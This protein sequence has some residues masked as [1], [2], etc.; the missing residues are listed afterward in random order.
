MNLKL[1]QKNILAIELAAPANR[2]RIISALAKF[3]TNT[4]LLTLFLWSSND[5]DRRQLTRINSTKP[6][7]RPWLPDNKRKRPDNAT[8]NHNN[9]PTKPAQSFE[10]D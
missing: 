9:H 7:S 8:T 10:N 5:P 4:N 1:N 3:L 2:Q 6:K